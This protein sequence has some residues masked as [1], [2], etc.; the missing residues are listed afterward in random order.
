ME[1]ERKEYVTTRS[2]YLYTLLLFAKRNAVICKKNV[3]MSALIYRHTLA[4]PY[5]VQKGP[6]DDTV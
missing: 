3:I 4:I 1:R 5:V 2:V 6:L